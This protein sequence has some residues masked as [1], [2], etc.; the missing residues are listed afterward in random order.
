MTRFQFQL[1]MRVIVHTDQIWLVWGQQR[2]IE[3]WLFFRIDY[4]VILLVDFVC[5]LWQVYI[6][7]VEI[8]N[9]T[10]AYSLWQIYQFQLNALYVFIS[11]CMET[12]VVVEMY[13]YLYRVNFS[14]I[15]IL[16]YTRNMSVFNIQPTSLI[17]PT[18]QRNMS[19][20]YMYISYESKNNTCMS[21][22]ELKLHTYTYIAYNFILIDMKG[23]NATSAG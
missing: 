11:V 12:P 20:K 1:F 16:S 22:S 5:E 10:G 3:H 21:N 23:Y 6:L 9:S 18:G 8:Y 17:F 7:H 15:D 19:N 2:N 4:V 13:V 14:N